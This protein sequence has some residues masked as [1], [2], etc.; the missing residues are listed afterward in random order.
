MKY[1]SQWPT[2]TFRSTVGSYWFIIPN[3]DVGILNNSQDIRQKSLDHEIYYD[4]NHVVTQNQYPKYHINPWNSLQNIRQNRW[5]MKIMS[6]RPW[7]VYTECWCDKTCLMPILHYSEVVCI[8]KLQYTTLLRCP[9]FWLL[10]PYWN[11]TWGSI[12]VEWKRALPGTP[13]PN[14]KS[15]W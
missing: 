8:N 15:F 9:K 2:F 10:A 13:I 14:M 12:D 3:N 7:L 1:R 6:Q 4:V 11:M 5:S